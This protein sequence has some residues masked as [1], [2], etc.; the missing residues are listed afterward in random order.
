MK[1]KKVSRKLIFSLALKM[2][3]FASFTIA[4]SDKCEMYK[5]LLHMITSLFI[6]CHASVKMKKFWNYM[7]WREPQ[8]LVQCGIHQISLSFIGAPKNPFSVHQYFNFRSPT[9]VECAVIYYHFAI[10]KLFF[11]YC[12]FHCWCY[13]K[14]W[15]DIKGFHTDK[16]HTHILVHH[17]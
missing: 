4:S 10:E 16:I 1:V 15:S 3:N 6:F 2:K 7:A 12:A 17:T 11:C 14:I 9:S 13:W 8:L 5:I